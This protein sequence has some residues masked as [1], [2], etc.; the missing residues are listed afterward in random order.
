MTID[1]FNGDSFD[2][3]NLDFIHGGNISITQTGS[4]P[5]ATNVIQPDTPTW[6]AEFKKRSIHN[7]TRT[8][9]LGAQ[10]ASISHKENY[11][12]LDGTYK[13]A[14]GVPFFK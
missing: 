9:S 12:S 10:G 11:L 14:Y 5:I 7:Y 6:G 8:L 4:R 1:D 2:H 13:D 3:S